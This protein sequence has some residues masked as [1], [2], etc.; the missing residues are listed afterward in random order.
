MINSIVGLLGLTAL[1]TG[2][3]L[4]M[5]QQQ[6]QEME[7]DTTPFMLRKL[8][9]SRDILSGLAMENYTL[10]SRNAQDLMLLSHEA[11]WKVITTPEY[12]K[13]SAE[14][15]ASAERLRDTAKSENLDGATLAYIEVTL[16]CVRCH[17]YIRSDYSEKK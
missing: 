1:G 9:H 12:L 10:I 11:D 15:R 7:K 16:N 6:E 13:M 4:A 8:D 5:P 14:F 2:A 3:M 17:K